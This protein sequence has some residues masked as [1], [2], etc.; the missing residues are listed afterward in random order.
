M[1][2]SGTTITINGIH[3]SAIN[4]AVK[5][6]QKYREKTLIDKINKTMGDI[7]ARFTE[8]ASEAFGSSVAFSQTK[9]GDFAYEITAFSPDGRVLVTFLEFGT[10]YYADPTHE[11]ADDVDFNV[12]PGSWSEEHANTWFKWLQAGKDPAKYPYNHEPRR[13]MLKG[14]EAARKYVESMA[15]RIK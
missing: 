7:C 5:K 8:V 13:G 14:M 3:P 12:Y 2:R 10:G 9:V 4:G 6:I 11:Y 1:S 15:K